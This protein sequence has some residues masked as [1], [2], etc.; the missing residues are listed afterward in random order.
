MQEQIIHLN[1]ACNSHRF[2]FTFRNMN[3][4]EGVLVYK[5]M[6]KHH[7]C[8]AVTSCNAYKESKPACNTLHHLVSTKV[9]LIQPI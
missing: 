5:R 2:P 4:F 1:Q 3:A 7:T 8:K 9:L 6:F